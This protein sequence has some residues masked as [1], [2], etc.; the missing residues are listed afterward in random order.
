MTMRRKWTEAEID[1]LKLTFP[2]TGTAKIAETLKRTYGSVSST[3][4]II[5]L[6]KSKEFLASEAGRLK[7]NSQ[8]GAASRF[9]KG[10]TPANK[11]KRQV[12]YMSAEQIARTE[13]SR[14]NKGNLPHNTKSDF[15]VTIR[16]DNRGVKIKFIRVALGKWV[17]L[18]RYH[19]EQENG[20]I[21]KGL[22]LIFKD[23]N[24]MNCDLIN[25]ELV[26]AADLLKRNSINNYPEELVQL[27][28]LRGVLNRKINTHIKKLN[29]EKQDQ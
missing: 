15:T 9:K 10:D 19:W 16:P 4:N 22:K 25:L 8:V 24:T 13:K 6:K 1:F 29:D 7:K 2:D 27:V 12:E 17:P 23:G 20:P 21:P 28:R 3:A 5:G 26:T 18:H 14:F 11:G